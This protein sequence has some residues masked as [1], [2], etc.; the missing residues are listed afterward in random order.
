MSLDLKI[1]GG[2]VVDG[3]GGDRFTADIGIR[4]GQIVE[5]GRISTPARR[6]IPADGA[7]VTPGFIDM[8]THY[9]AQVLWD[10]D[11]IASSRNGVT[12]GV[13]GNCGVGCA[14]LDP[15]IRSDLISLLEGVEDI[16][17][18]SI[19][20][21]LDWRWHS[22]ASYLEAVEARPHTINL[23]ANATHAPLR[24]IAMGARAFDG[25]EPRED[26]IAN[27]PRQHQWHRFEV[28]I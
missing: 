2:T 11:L 25:S 13:M 4:D 5:L 3:T 9:D 21:A 22:F 24:M 18:E 1:I 12:S 14:P 20:A 26:D 10:S 17:R 27:V 19:E 7:L 8:H 28:V 23:A 16:P 6:V 15:A